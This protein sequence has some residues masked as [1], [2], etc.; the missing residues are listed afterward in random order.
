MAEPPIAGLD[1]HHARAVAAG[2]RRR[3]HSGHAASED[4]KVD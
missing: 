4:E 3:A 1:E 2:A